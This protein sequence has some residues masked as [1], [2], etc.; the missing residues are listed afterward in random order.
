ME[1][2]L[3]E[4]Q[5]VEILSSSSRGLTLTPP[6]EVQ[7]SLRHYTHPCASQEGKLLLEILCYWELGLIVLVKTK[8]T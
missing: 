4:I 8:F 5:L 2:S 6:R 1:I 7:S 3:I